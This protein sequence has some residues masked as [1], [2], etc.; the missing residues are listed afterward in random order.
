MYRTIIIAAVVA[1]VAFSHY[2]VYNHGYDKGEEAVHAL[3]TKDKLQQTEQALIKQQQLQ[4]E[5]Q[6]SDERYVNEK[7]KA[8][9]AAAAAQSELDRLRDVLADNN[10]REESG[11]A[12][13]IPGTHGRAGL[14]QE[15]LGQ[16]AATLVAMAAEADRLEAVV[17]GLQS[18]VNNVCLF[19]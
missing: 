5:K 10:N 2:F 14:E 7:R 17:V 8:A 11:S 9:V 3:W 1:A 16:C 6:K 15:L 4:K 18:Y 19:K 12:S 13:T